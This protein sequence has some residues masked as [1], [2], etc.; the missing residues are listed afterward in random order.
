MGSWKRMILITMTILWI[1][2]FLMMMMKRSL[3]L[4]TTTGSIS[5]GLKTQPFGG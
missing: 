5:A 3:Q 4:Q 2:M 1:M